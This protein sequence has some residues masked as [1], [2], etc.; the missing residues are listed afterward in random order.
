MR[1]AN[2]IGIESQ[3]VH[4]STETTE[5]DLINLIKQFNTDPTVH[6]I[7][8]QVDAILDIVETVIGSFDGN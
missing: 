3:H 1:D 8:V 5:M 4:L 7:L 6:G 2:K